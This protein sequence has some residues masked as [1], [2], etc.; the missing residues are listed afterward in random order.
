MRRITDRAELADLARELRVRADWHE[1]DEQNLTA[2]VHGQSF[3]N[4][5]SPG[6]WYGTDIA[7]TPQ[8]E[9]H[10]ILRLYG[11][12]SDGPALPVAVVNLATL[13]SW[14]ASASAEEGRLRHMGEVLRRE[15]ATLLRRAERAEAKVAAL[16]LALQEASDGIGKVLGH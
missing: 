6:E 10:V 13:F 3:D 1:P 5:M 16:L 4:A 12:E 8:A 2:T 11:V 7:G 15:N 14:A 9:M